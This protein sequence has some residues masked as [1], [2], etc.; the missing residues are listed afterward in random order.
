MEMEIKRE[1]I[2]PQTT[3][4]A[5]G[6][7]IVIDRVGSKKPAQALKS[8]R[9]V[10]PPSSKESS[11]AVDTKVESTTM[12]RA[13]ADKYPW[14]ADSIAEEFGMPVAS[15]RAWKMKLEKDGKIAKPAVKSLLCIP[16]PEIPK[17]FR[18]SDSYMQ[19]LRALRGKVTPRR[20]EIAPS[21]MQHA[22]LKILVPVFDDT[23]AKFLL[24]KFGDE[25]G[26]QNYLRNHL[27]EISKPAIS[28]IEELRRKF[29][30]D[31]AE[32]LGSM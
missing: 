28:K 16:D 6:M 4:K 2:G 22:K 1:R 12:S 25:R 15:F 17:R 19:K 30:E 13:M 10:I 9:V 11:P 32:L 20:K 27:V 8:E 23:V 5:A 26:L 3:K 14:T 18:Y 24:K 31:M 7:E 21:A 29:E